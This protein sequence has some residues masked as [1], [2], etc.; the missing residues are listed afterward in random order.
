MNKKERIEKFKGKEKVVFEQLEGS[1]IDYLQGIQYL[2]DTG[3]IWACN[4]MLV[5]LA[6]E[7]M[8]KGICVDTEEPLTDEQLEIWNEILIEW[9]NRLKH[10]F[11]LH[12]KRIR[13]YFSKCV[14][15]SPLY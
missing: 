13:K 8:S 11:W 5:E 14:F 12:H 4:K 7:Y 6:V 3:K 10:Q 2:I 15:D 9:E 1:P